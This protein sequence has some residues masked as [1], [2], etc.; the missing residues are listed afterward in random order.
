MKV[1]Y[2]LDLPMDELMLRVKGLPPDSVIYYLL[3]ALTQ[4][5]GTFYQACEDNLGWFRRR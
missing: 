5:T 1:E 4:L 3:I 2:L